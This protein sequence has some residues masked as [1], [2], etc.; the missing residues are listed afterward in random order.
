MSRAGWLLVL[1]S[2]AVVVVVL[3]GAAVTGGSVEVNASERSTAKQLDACAVFTQSDAQTILGPAAVGT[4]PE[5]GSCSYLSRPP[6]ASPGSP[7]PTLVTI[8]IYDGQPLSVSES[9]DG[10]SPQRDTSVSGLGNEARWYFYG[11]GA[12]GVLDVHKGSH[13]VR[14]MVGDAPVNNKATAIATARV[15]LSRL[16]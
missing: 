7:P 3:V 5:M 4:R 16:S 10:G 11:R 12:A 8:N 1:A 2:L 15:I 13:V 6:V 9:Y 14:L